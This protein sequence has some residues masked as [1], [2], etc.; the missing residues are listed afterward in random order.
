MDTSVVVGVSRVQSSLER[1]IQKDTEAIRAG[2]RECLEAV[3][4]KADF[5]VP[6]RLG[7]LKASRKDAILKDSV[8]V[9]GAIWYDAPYA[10]FVHEE[11][12]RFHVAPT[13]AKWLLRSVRESKQE[14]LQI[15]KK[16]VAMV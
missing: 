7:V 1:M 5:Y 6:V 2:M 12:N 3:N 15:L 16:Y 4:K 8:G 14:C 10:L 9:D 11:V 13:C